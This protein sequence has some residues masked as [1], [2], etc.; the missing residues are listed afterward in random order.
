MVYKEN[1]STARA[2]LRNSVLK[3]Q[4]AEDR[5]KEREREE[6]ERGKESQELILLR[7]TL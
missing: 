4:G 6:E 3:N 1:S 7:P 2:N 5:G